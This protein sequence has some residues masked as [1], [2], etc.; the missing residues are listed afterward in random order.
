MLAI[1][2]GKKR[3]AIREGFS[4]HDAGFAYRVGKIVAPAY[5]WCDDP[6]VECAAG[7]HFYLT[8]R[9]AEEHAA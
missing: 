3:E 8:R 1:F 6:R 4:L 5:G 9:E 7:I 2:R